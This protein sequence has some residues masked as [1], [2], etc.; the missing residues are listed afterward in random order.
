[1][2]IK[3][4]IQELQMYDDDK[5]IV[6]TIANIPPDMREFV[7]LQT[8]WVTA[9]SDYRA[10]IEFNLLPNNQLEIEGQW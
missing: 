9:K 5:E 1:M 2:T 3:E 7:D 10:G 6:L 4:L 8:G